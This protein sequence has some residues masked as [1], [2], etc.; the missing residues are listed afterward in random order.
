MHCLCILKDNY[1][2]ETMTVDTALALNTNAV[3]LLMGSGKVQDAIDVLR[4]TLAILR[5][6]LVPIVDAGDASRHYT[7]EDTVSDNVEHCTIRSVPMGVNNISKAQDDDAFSLFERAILIEGCDQT[8][9][10]TDRL[11]TRIAVVV[12]YNLGLAH[13]LLG[14]QNGNYQ[15]ENFAKALRF[16]ETADT[17]N[18]TYP[19]NR[20]ILFLAAVNNAAYLHSHFFNNG[21]TQTC[22][23]GMSFV[24]RS[25]SRDEKT[26][27]EYSPFFMNVM[28]YRQMTVAPAA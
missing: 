21:N 8:L 6:C 18:R 17:L 13:H 3:S 12:T 22:L 5:D 28:F 7:A 25:T 11:L 19:D 10:P 26:S 2:G 4:E 23:D 16:Y 24:L 14:L 1:S 20:G 9:A 15:R 27:E